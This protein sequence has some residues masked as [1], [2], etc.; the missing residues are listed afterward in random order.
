MA[1]TETD[2]AFQIRGSQELLRK[3]DGKTLALI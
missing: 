1:S 3:I 2:E